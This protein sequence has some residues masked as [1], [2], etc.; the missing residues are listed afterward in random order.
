MADIIQTDRKYPNDPA[1][2]SLEVV[3]AGR[4]LYDQIWLGS[5]MSGGVGFTQYATAAYTDNVLDDF[6]YYGVDYL[7]DKYKGFA[8]APAKMEV[9]NDL[10]TEVTLYGMEQ[11]R[12]SSRPSWRTTSAVPSVLPSLRPLPVSPSP[13]LPRTPTPASAA[14]TSPC[15][16]TRKAG[17]GSGSTATTCRTSAVPRTPCPSGPTR[18]WSTSSVARTTRTTR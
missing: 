15:S 16:S 1:R 9:V 5:Y 13:L 17:A 18:A 12:D 8:K 3:A 4:M 10:A 7:K 2:S 6:T 14:G 11:D